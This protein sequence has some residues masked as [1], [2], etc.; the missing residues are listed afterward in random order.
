M[1]HQIQDAEEKVERSKNIVDAGGDKLNK[2][3]F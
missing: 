3:V 2:G 1:R